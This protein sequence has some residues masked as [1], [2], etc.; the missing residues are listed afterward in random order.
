M[1]EGHNRRHVN[2]AAKQAPEMKNDADDTHFTSEDPIK[3]PSNDAPN[4]SKGCSTETR[5]EI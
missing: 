5:W 1:S 3:A 2:K 4:A